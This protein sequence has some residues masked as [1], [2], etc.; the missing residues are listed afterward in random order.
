MQAQTSRKN[1]RDRVLEALIRARG[2]EIPACEL[3]KVGG[4]QFQTRIYELRHTFGFVIENRKVKNRDGTV[5]SF[6][7]LVTGPNSVLVP[8]PVTQVALHAGT[9]GK[10]GGLASPS[11]FDLSPS[12]RHRDDG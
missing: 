12:P 6:Y 10:G 9:E 5:H 8:H 1:H 7:R 2:V 11:L 3:A 4:L